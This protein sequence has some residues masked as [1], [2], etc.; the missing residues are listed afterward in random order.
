M[1]FTFRLKSLLPLI[2]MWGVL[3]CGAGQTIV[4]TST[5]LP[6]TN[7]PTPQPILEP[8]NTPEPA[9]TTIS[10]SSPYDETAVP[11]KDIETALINAERDEKLVL[12]DFGAN[13]CPDCVVLSTLFEDPFVRPYLQENFYVVK[14][15]VGEWDKNLDISQQYG[16][17][18]DN[19]IPAV[20]VLS[21]NGDIIATTKDGALANARTATAQEILGYLKTWVAEKP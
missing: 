14:I 17:P 20:V 7:Q 19:G 18:I 15:D 4:A 8:I 13:W 12:L 1:K 3:A 10:P 16:N 21:A 2:V 11:Q 6:A 5:P 9:N